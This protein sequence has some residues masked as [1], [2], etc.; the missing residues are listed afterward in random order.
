MTQWRHLFSLEIFLEKGYLVLNGL[1]TSSKSYGDEI[2]AIVKNRTVTPE[3]KWKKVTHKRYKIDNSFKN[4]VNEFFD[5]II[6]NKP[7]RNGNSKD[8]LELMIIIDKI[9]KKNI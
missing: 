5:A 4:E 1:V 7:I 3:A 9:Y 6:K 2:L 8:A